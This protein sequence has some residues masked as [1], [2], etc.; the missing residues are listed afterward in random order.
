MFPFWARRLAAYRAVMS[1]GDAA[2][3]ELGERRKPNKERDG[4]TSV[5]GKTSSSSP[6]SDMA[7]SPR[8]AIWLSCWGWVPSLTRTTSATQER[9]RSKTSWQSRPGALATVDAFEA[10]A[11]DAN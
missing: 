5:S 6:L 10:R 7:S 4:I 3:A 8:A 1:L 11:A 9:A 2:L